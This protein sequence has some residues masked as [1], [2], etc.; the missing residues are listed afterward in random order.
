MILWKAVMTVKVKP[1]ME[2][3]TRITLATVTS[4]LSVELFTFQADYD[5]H[6]DMN[7]KQQRYQNK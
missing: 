4:T 7:S 2:V 5:N 3:Y 1:N 6:Y